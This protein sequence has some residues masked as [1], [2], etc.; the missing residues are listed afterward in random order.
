ME[1]NLA[2][3]EHLHFKLDVSVR[4]RRLISYLSCFL[5][6]EYTKTHT[7]KPHIHFLPSFM[8]H[9]SYC[10]NFDDFLSFC[11]TSEDMCGCE[12]SPTLSIYIWKQKLFLKEVF[13][14]RQKC[15][16]FIFQFLRSAGCPIFGPGAAALFMER[17]QSP[18]ECTALLTRRSF[19]IRGFKSHPLRQ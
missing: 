2:H 19:G 14:S 16:F 5:K 1:N 4:F 9:Y 7:G 8:S 15:L 13:T 6:I 3:V 12:N 10:V 18:A 17:W 11:V